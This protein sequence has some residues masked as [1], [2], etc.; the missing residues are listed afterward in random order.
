MADVTIKQGDTWPPLRGTAASEADGV[1]DLFLADSMK[2]V[3]KQHGG[4]VT[5]TATPTALNPA[6]NDGFNWKYDWADTD[7]AVIGEYDV[8]LEVTWDAT[9]TPDQVQT[10]PNSGYQTLEVSADLGGDR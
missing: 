9:T 2:V 8:E 4:G 1:V 6:T 5:I 7:T 3:I 10:F